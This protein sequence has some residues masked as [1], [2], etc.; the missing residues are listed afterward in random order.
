MVE[1]YLK[2]MK[3][4]DEPDLLGKLIAF[5]KL[6][7]VEPRRRLQRPTGSISQQKMK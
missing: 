6:P 2:D 1:L 5:E 7:I 3:E 4:K